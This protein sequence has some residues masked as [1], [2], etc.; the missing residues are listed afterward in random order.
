MFSEPVRVLH[1]LH[2]MAQGGA[3]TM[4]MN[5]YRCIDR[6]QLQFDFLL[7]S[8]KKGA[9]EDE[10]LE[11]GGR[12]YRL[13]LLT[14]FTPWKY[15]FA[16]HRF[17]KNHPEYKIV[18]SH[19]SS[20]STFPLWIAKINHVP[21]RICHSHIAKSE[22]GING[23]IR[24]FLKPF[25]KGVATDYFSCGRDAAV[26]LYGKKFC[27]SHEV[28]ILNNAI[29]SSWYLENKEVRKEMRVKMNLDEN[30]VVGH[31]GRFFPQKNHTFILDVFRAIHD[32]N[33]LA[34]LLLVGDGGLRHEIEKKI[35]ALDLKDSVILTGNVPD[36][37]NYM[38]AM[39]IFLFPSN[40]EGL[41]LVLI[42]AQAAGLRC[43]SSAGAVTEE[44][45]L[46]GLIEYIP[47]SKPAEYWA[48]RILR[49]AAGYER[50]DTY[51]QIVKS[52]YDAETA[53]EWI[54]NFYLQKY[55]SLSQ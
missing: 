48:D 23:Y 45:N 9:Y 35:L 42:E 3:E 5:Y 8:D 10:I 41:P 34:K 25:L 17:F 43:F 12:I 39:D 26:W 11:L 40:Y 18:H 38:Q 51:E 1:I 27:D 28:M 37:Y 30:F 32:K 15:L 47:L 2:G 22:Q 6:N 54:Q 33:P 14:K 4:L 29:H 24:D 49:C 7:T 55:K 13:P 16:I 21:V 44:V 53:V 36:V 31:V 19:T 46:A 52:G 50:I 20:K